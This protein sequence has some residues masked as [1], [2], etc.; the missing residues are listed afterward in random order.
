MV[1]I[2]YYH[3]ILNSKIPF[4]AAKFERKEGINLYH[5]ASAFILTNGPLL[6]FISCHCFFG[7]LLGYLDGL[8]LYHILRRVVDFFSCYT[9]VL[10]KRRVED[11]EFW[12]R[13]GCVMHG[14]WCEMSDFGRWAVAR[15]RGTKVMIWEGGAG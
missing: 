9:L 15:K 1:I 12:P 10:R 6:C 14:A 7:W 4:P 13:G 3:H 5:S 8:I 2:I 11:D